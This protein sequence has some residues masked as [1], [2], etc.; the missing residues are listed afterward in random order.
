MRNIGGLE[1]IDLDDLPV[2]GFK[3]GQALSLMHQV[4]ILYENEMYFPLLKHACL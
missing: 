2:L 3:L 4:H 1:I